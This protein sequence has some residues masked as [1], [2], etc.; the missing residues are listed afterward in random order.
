LIPN[1]SQANH[2]F[3]NVVICWKAANTSPNKVLRRGDKR[4]KEASAARFFGLLKRDRPRWFGFIGGE[5]CSG[6]W[7]LKVRTLAR[8]VARF[9]TPCGKDGYLSPMEF[10]RKAGFA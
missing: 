8:L 6:G 4:T 3:C 2:T 7:R 1:L 9:D 10:E 5:I